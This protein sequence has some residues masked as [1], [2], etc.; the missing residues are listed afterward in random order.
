M[1][2]SPTKLTILVALT[3][4]LSSLAGVII[5]SIFNLRNARLSKQSEERR[6]QRELIINAA[7][8]NWKQA[9]EY[10]K[11]ANDVG[12]ILPLNDYIVLMF[13]FSEI[14][15]DDKVDSSNVNKKLAELSEFTSKFIEY[16]TRLFEEHDKP[17]QT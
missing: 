9:H 14:M 15:L 3:A 10:A 16:R 6:H 13:K 5:T 4:A 8:T 1:E 11:S 17:R 2:I 12:I 7:I